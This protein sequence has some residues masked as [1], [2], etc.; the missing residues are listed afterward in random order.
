[1]KF[2][3]FSLLSFF[4]S[5]AYYLLFTACSHQEA[6]PKNPPVAVNLYTAKSEIVTYYDKYPANTVALSQVDLRPEVQ[7]YIT[8]IDFTEGTHVKKGQKLYEIDQRLYQDAYDQAKANAEVAEGNLKQAQQDADRYTYLNSQNAVAKQTLD[9]ALVALENAKNSLKAAEQAV[10]M[11]ATN[12]TYSI[13]SAPFDGTIGFSQVKLGNMVTVGT[14]ILNTIST[15]DPMGVDFLISEKQLAHFDELKNNTQQTLDSLF[16][17]VLPNDSIYTQLGK[18]SVIDRAVDQQTGTIRV[19]AVFPNPNYSLKPGLSCV[20]RV[21][22]QETKPK[23]LVPSKAVVELMGEYFVYLVKDTTAPDP[24][25]STKT[26]PVTIA[27]QKKVKL[28]QT[29]APNV[30]VENGLKEGTK[31]VL[32]GVQS[33]H[34]GSV[35]KVGQ[36]PEGAK[37]GKDSA[38]HKPDSQPTK[39]SSK[40][41]KD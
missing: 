27:V 3:N 19:R 40:K 36:K 38:S 41:G 32:D 7:G 18:I 33:L 39:D 6:P 8:A 31:I 5:L 11:A 29:I 37:G 25:D 35:I 10:K 13:I 17:I 20:M 2:H 23:L 14:T 30:I 15:D 34:T 16:T 21:H 22:N 4:F 28:G 12:L 26:H 24:K 9:H 1:M